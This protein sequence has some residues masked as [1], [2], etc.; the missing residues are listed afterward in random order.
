MTKKQ[1]RMTKNKAGM[2]KENSNFS[3][4]NHQCA[5][6]TFKLMRLACLKIGFCGGRDALD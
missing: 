5:C 4:P 1:G 3:V 6:V 2:T